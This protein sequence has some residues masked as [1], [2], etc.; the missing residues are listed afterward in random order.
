MG[1]V[2]ETYSQK[3]IIFKILVCAV[4]ELQYYWTMEEKIV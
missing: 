1:F 2:M 4:F 3:E